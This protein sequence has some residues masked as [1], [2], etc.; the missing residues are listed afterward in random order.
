MLISHIVL[1][2]FPGRK[3]L[4]YYICIRD[5]PA[6]DYNLQFKNR[7]F[8]IVL[9]V[10]SIILC[11]VIHTKIK[12][13]IKKGKT[14]TNKN[15]PAIVCLGINLLKNKIALLM[16]LTPMVVVLLF[17]VGLRI[18]EPAKMNTFPLKTSKICRSCKIFC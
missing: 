8:T 13:F 4:N 10:L 17:L 1:F 7:W 9:I 15:S 2:F 6:S 11:S 12:L 3:T 16:V 18:M 14:T 5:F